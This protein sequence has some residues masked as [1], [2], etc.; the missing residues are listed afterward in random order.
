MLKGA[1][2]TK[3]G[4]SVVLGM[5][6][7]GMRLM[8]DDVTLA[9]LAHY[10]HADKYVRGVQSWTTFKAIDSVL[11]AGGLLDIFHKG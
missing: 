11:S 3:V 2:A 6:P 9:V 10:G 8:N 5:L 7:S 1:I 4:G